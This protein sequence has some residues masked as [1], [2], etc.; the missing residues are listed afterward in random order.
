MMRG[1]LFLTKS[2][3]LLK[4]ELLDTPDFFGNTLSCNPSMKLVHLI[5]N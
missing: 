3:I 4:Y 2:E 1:Q 5:W